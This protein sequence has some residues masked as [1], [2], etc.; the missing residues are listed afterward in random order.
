MHTIFRF[1]LSLLALSAVAL[2]ACEFDL[3]PGGNNNDEV[4]AP[5]STRLNHT[6]ML[7]RGNSVFVG[8]EDGIWHKRI[9]SSDDW[10]RIDDLAGVRIFAVRRDPRDADTFFA[11]GEPVDDREA[12][13]FYRSDDGGDTWEPST[14]WPRNPFDDSTETFFDFVV[15]PDDSDRL[16][17]NLSGQSIAISTDGG[18]TWTLANGATEV[19]FGDPCVLHIL[20]AQPRKL[21][22][23]C[24]APLDDA[25]VATYDI[26]TNDPF[27][28]NNFTF[29]A[30]GLDFALGNR[31]PNS[32]ASSSARP[33]TVYVGLEGA[34]IALEGT[35]FEPVFQ[36]ADD[37]SD[38]LP[39]AFIKGIWVDPNDDQHLIFGGGINGVNTE[40]SLFETRDHGE[41]IEQLAGPDESLSDPSVEQILPFGDERLA[42]LISED[43]DPSD[44]NTDRTLRVFVLDS[45]GQPLD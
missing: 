12:A 9:S 32:I 27:N 40:L 42:V 19:N 21:Y 13:P 33:D 20:R 44:D 25:W 30:G 2:T 26:D 14:T 11:A 41:T 1:R 36:V 4:P 39:Y 6:P 28:L 34:L 35:T 10:E 24:E 38:D 18:D 17:A 16:Y 43:D 45:H 8:T 22:Q 5:A 31:R 23:G 7:I 37:G 29:V 15:A 3:S